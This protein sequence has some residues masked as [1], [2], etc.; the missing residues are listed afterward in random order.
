MD[1]WL[2][3]AGGDRRMKRTEDEN[4]FSKAEGGQ[5]RNECEDS[6]YEGKTKSDEEA[7]NGEAGNTGAIPEHAAFLFSL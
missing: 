2:V 3:R 6:D 1:G 4:N 5:R 7:D